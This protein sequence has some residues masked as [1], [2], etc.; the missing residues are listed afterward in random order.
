MDI[1]FKC[2]NFFS[3]FTVFSKTLY[4]DANLYVEY[5]CTRR[6]ADGYCKT[7]GIQFNVYSRNK[8]ADFSPDEYSVDDVTE[9]ISDLAESVCLNP[10][11]LHMET[12]VTFVTVQN[13]ASSC[14]NL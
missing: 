13:T 1:K 6:S 9:L 14:S 10:D 11:H 3:T 2:S 5:V 4:L 12:G 8:T 7:G